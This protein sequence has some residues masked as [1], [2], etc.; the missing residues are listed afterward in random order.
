M[1]P[2]SEPTPSRRVALSFQTRLTLTILAAAI[3]PLAA[4][5]ILLIVSG[6]VDPQVGSR[7]LLFMFAVAVAVGILGGAVVGLDLVRPLREIS[8]AVSRVSAGDMSQPIPVVGNDVLAQLAES[9]NRLAGD[10]QRRNHQLGLILAAV[11]SAEPRDGVET[12]AERAAHD[13]ETA[14]G[15][16]SAELRFVDPDS[17]ESE[18]RIPG[19]SLPVRAELRAGDDRM[20]LI[21]A[22]L[23][24]TRTWE[25]ADQALL[26]LYA[27]EIGVAIRNAE[28]FAQ[29][30][31][32]NVQLRRLSEVKDD[33][34]RGV[35]HN[36]QTPLTSIKSNA[37]ALAASD[38]DP[39]LS[40][41]SDQADRLS[42]MVQQLL[43][44]SRLESQPPRPNA[45]VLAIGPRIQRAWDALGVAERP[46]ELHDGAP[47]WLAVADG[48]Q[49]DQVLW[50][51]LDNAVKYGEGTIS[52]EIGAEPTERRL[53]ATISDEGRGLDDSDRAWLFGRFERGVAGRTS[54]NG[55]G[56]GLYVSRAL[57]RG[58]GGDL[59]LDDVVAG[60][61]ATFRL[62]LPGESAHEG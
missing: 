12:L 16:I 43:L 33:F 40:N 46:M 45:D 48:D 53:W 42:R 15:F 44:V 26:D 39:R 38:P 17:V 58:M 29:I 35:S 62:T 10:A 9:H 50:A 19:V 28:L 32:K 1:I 7:L 25:R 54:G 36:L 37:E 6:A 59:V 60:R 24:A 14:F 22:S 30:Q 3:V 47:D 56:L 4:F 61:G 41:I 18:E 8:A 23:P 5:G 13:A 21:L 20:G 2:T 49:L 34:L 51:L 11:D 57:M 55:S 52:V 31:E 27:S